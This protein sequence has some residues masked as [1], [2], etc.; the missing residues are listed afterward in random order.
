MDK[1]DDNAIN[2]N[3][4]KSINHDLIDKLAESAFN[5][6]YRTAE[7]DDGCSGEYPDGKETLEL[8][9]QLKE[10]LASVVVF[11]SFPNDS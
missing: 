10:L 4:T 1:S 8:K 3:N 5:D 6:G 2:F 7:V 9:L 11:P